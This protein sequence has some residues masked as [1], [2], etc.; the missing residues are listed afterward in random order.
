VGRARIDE[1]RIDTLETI[2]SARGAGSCDSSS[3][4]HRSSLRTVAAAASLT[5]RRRASTRLLGRSLPDLDPQRMPTSTYEPYAQRASMAEV[6]R[7][8]LLHRSH[9]DTDLRLVANAIAGRDGAFYQ[10][11]PPDYRFRTATRTR[12][13][14]GG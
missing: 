5:R 3:H 14:R 8:L 9:P 12:S 2:E 13:R 7:C 11:V 6:S 1:S 4:G 10:R